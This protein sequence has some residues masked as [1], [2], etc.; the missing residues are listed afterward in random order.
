MIS[1]EE[2]SEIQEIQKDAIKKL[3]EKFD[4]IELTKVCDC[5]IQPSDLGCPYELDENDLHKEENAVKNNVIGTYNGL[6]PMI[7]EA[8]EK[9]KLAIQS[10]KEKYRIIENVIDSY[11]KERLFDYFGNDNHEL[12]NY[13]L[14][15]AYEDGHS[16]GYSEILYYFD[17]YSSIA[18]EV[19][20]LTK[21]S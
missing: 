4:N 21:N 18:N 5:R 17:K 12:F 19:I 10:H 15:L 1:S 11:I 2:T 9:D 14:G 6:L 13:L 8:A 7:R 20:S 3:H 16:N